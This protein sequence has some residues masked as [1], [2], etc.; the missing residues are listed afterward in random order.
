M[1]YETFKY[2]PPAAISLCLLAEQYE[3]ALMIVNTLSGKFEISPKI[4]MDLCK[5]VNLIEKPAFFCIL[6]FI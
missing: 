6:L 1:L 3:L 4:L 2:N 5:L